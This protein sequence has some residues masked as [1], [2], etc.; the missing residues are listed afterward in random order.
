[1]FPIVTPPF[2]W[3]YSTKISKILEFKKINREMERKNDE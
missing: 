3:Y 1:M 2:K